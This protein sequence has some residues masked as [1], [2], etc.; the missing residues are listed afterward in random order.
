MMKLAGQIHFWTLGRNAVVG[1]V[2]MTVALSFYFFEL[3]R[4][5]DLLKTLM[6]CKFDKLPDAIYRLQ[7]HRQWA[8][9]NLA[10]ELHKDRPEPERVLLRLVSDAAPGPFAPAD[11][12]AANQLLCDQLLSADPA[13]I[14]VYTK[15]LLPTYAAE[16]QEPLRLVLVDRSY[17]EERRLRAACALV[18]IFLP[19]GLKSLDWDN[20]AQ[21]MVRVLSRNHAHHESMVALLQPA[22]Q[23]LLPR[24][25]Q[26]F[27]EA[28]ALDAGQC[29]GRE[30]SRPISIGTTTAVGRARH[31]L[32]S[33][34]V[35]AAIDSLWPAAASSS[36][37]Q[38]KR[39]LPI[40]AGGLVIMSEIGVVS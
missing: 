6:D 29:D 5:A 32:R 15:E 14:G 28:D 19:D 20:L 40:R 10:S 27:R 37:M 12:G 23:A 17:E 34:D 33:P 36:V 3:M 35:P 25:I 8:I 16:L 26:D 24:L 30:H 22:Q 21:L 2:L 7:C 1:L 39:F 38:P 18:S 13:D 9:S 11:A 31:R 4:R